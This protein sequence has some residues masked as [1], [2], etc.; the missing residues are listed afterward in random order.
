MSLVGRFVEDCVIIG[1]A[2]LAGKKIYEHLSKDEWEDIPVSRVVNDWD[3][4]D[5]DGPEFSI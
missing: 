1:V 2:Y 5:N 3:A 4:K